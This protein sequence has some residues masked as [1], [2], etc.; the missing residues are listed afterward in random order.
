MN[1]P[2]LAAVNA[3]DFFSDRIS[4]RVLAGHWCE[5]DVQNVPAPTEGKC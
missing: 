5:D 1:N 3:G 4:H 2:V